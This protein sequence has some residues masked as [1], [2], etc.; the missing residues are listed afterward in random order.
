MRKVGSVVRGLRLTP[1]GQSAQVDARCHRA[2]A[3][4]S[5]RCLAGAGAPRM[6]LGISDAYECPVN[7]GW[8]RGVVRDEE[9]LLKPRRGRQSLFIL[10]ISLHPGLINASMPT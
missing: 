7:G 5:A 10:S 9:D 1:R 8:A 4:R 6:P 2:T 3:R